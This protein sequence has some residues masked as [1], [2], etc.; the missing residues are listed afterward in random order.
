MTN[1]PGYERPEPPPSGAGLWLAL[2]LCLISA[3]GAAWI[4]T[5]G[6]SIE[7]RDLRWETPSG[8]TMSALLLRPDTA[9]A[10]TPA[11]AVVVSHGWFNNREMQDLNFVELSRR[12]YV[13][14]SIDMYGHGNSEALPQAQLMQRGIGMY[15][16]VELLA[17]LPYVNKASIGVSG[18]SNGA[19]AA[20]LSVGEDNRAKEQLIKAV[21]LVDRDPLYVDAET[22]EH[23]NVYGSR[24]VGVIQAEYD[25]FFFRSRGAKGEVLTPP[26]E[27]LQ[28]P[29]AQ[30]FLHFGADPTT[31][32][33]TRGGHTVY[34][35]AVDGGNAMR[36][37]YNLDQIHPWTHFSADAVRDQVAFFDQA[38][39]APQPIEP[40]SQIWQIRTAFTTLGLVGFGM[41][42]VAFS[43]TLLAHPFFAST[44]RACPPA[45][46]PVDAERLWFWGG[47]GVLIIVSGVT[48]IVLFPVAAMAQPAWLP[49]GP[50]FFVG[51]WAAVNGAFALL[52]VAVGYYAHGRRKGQDVR[53]TGVLIPARSLLLTALLALGVVTAAFAIVFTADYFF[54]TDFRIWVVAIKAFTP[55]KIAIAALYLPLFL[56]YFV[57]NSIVL[58]SF[59]R[60]LLLGRE[61]CNTALL[62]GA[63]AAAPLI[64]VVMQYSTFFSTGH[65]IGWFPGITSIWLFPIIVFLPVAAVISRKLYRATGN[66]YLGGFVNAGVV[67]MIAVSNTLTMG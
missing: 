2:L 4:Q 50:P 8:H 40:D 15:D 35:Q 14:L 43:R 52:V 49:Q 33:G 44:T 12:G 16:A 47:L 64:L 23:T 42:L 19:L 29:N 13:T 34:E 9:T 6:G 20:N 58:N 26:R 1:S 55:D 46:T 27:Y 59:S 18:H 28:T 66:P 17:A 61:G 67:T 62:A 36:V 60:Y 21:L 63:N 39:G 7:V 32:S 3:A 5:G 48:Y 38:L 54:K 37:I 53:A 30:S 41:F 57:A 22:R 24:D 65:T 11:P 25:E 10:E 51:L 31:L 56:V 45:R